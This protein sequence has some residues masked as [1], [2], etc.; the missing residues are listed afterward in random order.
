MLSQHRTIIT[1]MLVLA[2]AIG[3]LMLLRE[4]H[5]VMQT[6]LN[7]VVRGTSIAL[8]AFGIAL[9]FG[10]LRVISFAHGDLLTATAYLALVVGTYAGLPIV[11][12]GIVAVV[13]GAAIAA[14]SEVGLWSP[15]RRR[16]AGTLQKLLVGIGLAFFLR[17]VVQIIAGSEPR[18][19]NVSVTDSLSLPFDLRIGVAQLWALAIGGIALIAIAS[20]L[21]YSHSGRQL[22]ALSD[23]RV[24]AEASGVN[25]HR[26]TMLTWV[27]AGGTAGLAG[28]LT[29]ASVGV[30]TPIFG[31]V[32]LLSM[33]AA[34]VVG[35]I[36]STFGALAGGL[37]I[38][39]TEEW[40]TLF[41]EPTWKLAVGFTALIITLL[42]RP[43]G[44]LGRAVLR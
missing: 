5:A 8:G 33:F 2:V 18:R 31:F 14:L 27:I 6:T 30:V 11:V 9:V 23:N 39:L 41:I 4:P 37:L 15:L 24:L 1:F 22:R 12:A 20:F 7:G 44:L 25:S 26:W 13:A 28:V 38:G 17:G 19:L 40:S 29:A 10:V 21:K 3:G 32:L 36:H 42:V 34:T 43:T 35:G 16:G